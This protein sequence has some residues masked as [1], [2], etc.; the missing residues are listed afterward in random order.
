MYSLFETII[1]S[2]AAT[3]DLNQPNADLSHK[4]GSNGLNDNAIQIYRSLNTAFLLALVGDSTDPVQ[5]RNISR[6]YLQVRILNGMQKAGAFIPLA[7]HGGTALRFLYGLRR[8]SEDLDFA[9]ENP[10]RIMIFN[11]T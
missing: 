7:F 9:L 6:E 8:F 11:I 2:L 10:S 3:V 4:A 5:G 1:Q